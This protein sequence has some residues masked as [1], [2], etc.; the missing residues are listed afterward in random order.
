MCE[1][2]RKPLKSDCYTAVLRKGN[3]SIQII[4]IIIILASWWLNAAMDAID[5][6]KGGKT[7]Y[8]F[9]H[10]LKALSYGLL[11]GWIIYLTSGISWKWIFCGI[12][13]G[14]WSVIYR[15]L[16]FL[17]FYRLDERIKIPW[18]CRIWGIKR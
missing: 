17:E 11:I 13:L 8:E 5:H 7:L 15:L 14:L 3:M 2:G 10:I 16:R 18:L 1:V 12:G 4:S 9:W 6:A